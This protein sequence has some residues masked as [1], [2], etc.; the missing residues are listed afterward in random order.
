MCAQEEIEDEYIYKL[1]SLEKFIVK[2]KRKQVLDEAN[3]KNWWQMRKEKR[4]SCGNHTLPSSLFH[5]SMV[6]WIASRRYCCGDHLLDS[7]QYLLVCFWSQSHASDSSR[8]N[9][10]QDG[11]CDQ[12]T[13]AHEKQ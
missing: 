4:R 5:E 9:N 2:E 7:L 3:I 10:S 12:K 13:K 11:P 6:M 1:S 8:D